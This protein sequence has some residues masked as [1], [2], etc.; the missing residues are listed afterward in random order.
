[1]ERCLA[2]DEEAETAS[3]PCCYFHTPRPRCSSP[4]RSGSSG[5]HGQ[6]GR[7]RGLWESV[8]TAAS[9]EVPG[10]WEVTVGIPKR[11]GEFPWV[12]PESFPVPGGRGPRENRRCRLD[13]RSVRTCRLTSWARLCFGETWS[14]GLLHTGRSSRPVPGPARCE[15]DRW[16]LIPAG[17]PGPPGPPGPYDIIK[18]EPGL[19]G[20][21][22]PPGL[23]GLQGPPGPKGQ[24]G[25]A[26]GSCGRVR[27]LGAG[28]APP[29]GSL[30][31]EPPG[32]VMRTR[33]DATGLLSVCRTQGSFCRELQKPE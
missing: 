19:P 11:T 32:S 16:C 20:P 5:H 14:P 26:P 2:E 12:S 7:L 13:T 4:L 25:E 8:L 29:L 30:G 24:Q 6:R 17:L 10:F 33:L 18:G 15:T 9:A 27:E 31:S 1:M 21:E 28:R 22:G 3:P 23:K